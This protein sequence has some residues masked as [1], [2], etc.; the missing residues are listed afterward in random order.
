MTEQTNKQAKKKKPFRKSWEESFT[1][2]HSQGIKGREGEWGRK[3][4]R[5]PQSEVTR[6]GT[7]TLP[8]RLAKDGKIVKS[9]SRLGE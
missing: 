3:R 1:H 4:T 6:P 8:Y 7:G 5:L 2:T 9:I